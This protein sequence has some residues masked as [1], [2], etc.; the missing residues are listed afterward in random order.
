[1]IDW[2]MLH[3][4]EAA[5]LWAANF[6]QVFLLGFQSRNVN[7]G[8]YFLAGL[9]SMALAAFG[10]MVVKSQAIMPFWWLFVV[11]GTSGPAGIMFAMWFWKRTVGRKHA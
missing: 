7:T 3:L 4:P 11:I 8:Q 10:I 5:G 6:A 1:M 2:Q 9:T